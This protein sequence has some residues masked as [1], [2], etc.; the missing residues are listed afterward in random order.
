M[1]LKKAFTWAPILAHVDPQKPFIIKADLCCILSQQGDDKK[2]HPLSF[3]SHKFNTAEMNYE[4]H[5]KELL[6][7]VGSFAQ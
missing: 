6:A 1:D 2:L 5:D 7:I 4:V 3:D